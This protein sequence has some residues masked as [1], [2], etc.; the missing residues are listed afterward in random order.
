MCSAAYWIGSQAEAII[1][2]ETALVGNIGVYTVLEDT[3]VQAATEGRK[4]H[5]VKAGAH[6]AIGVDGAPI[7]EAQLAV[8]QDEINSVFRAFVKYT[9]AGRDMSIDRMM[10]LADGRAFSGP[11]AKMVNLVDE[12]GT[13]KDAIALAA[14]MADGTMPRRK[15]GA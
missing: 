4:V 3:S 11:E 5:I 15:T 1:A 9:A 12:V 6:K 13:L 7:T 14:G 2:N 10:G 8:V